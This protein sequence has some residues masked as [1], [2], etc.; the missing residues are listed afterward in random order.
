VIRDGLRPVPS[1]EVRA[2]QISDDR[3]AAVV[4]VEPTP[5][6]PC[7]TTDGAIFERVSGRTVP[8]REPDTLARL[9]DRGEAARVRA[10]STALGAVKR[11]TRPSDDELR[12]Q[13][14]GE[15][16]LLVESEGSA[17]WRSPR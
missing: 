13:A 7:I 16:M 17:G 10:E 12:P 6:P 1:F 15:A 14:S 3:A 2:W 9:Y 4:M 11:F 5:L 8:A